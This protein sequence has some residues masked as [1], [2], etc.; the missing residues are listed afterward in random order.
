MKPNQPNHRRPAP[1]STNG[2]LCGRIGSRFQADALAENQREGEARSTCVD[3]HRGTTG[4]VECLELGR[5]PAAVVAEVE[6]PVCDGEVDDRDP[7]RHE[8]RPGAELGAV[9]DGAADQR[10][11]DDREHQLE[12]HEDVLGDGPVGRLEANAVEAEALEAAEELV[13]V[14]AE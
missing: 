13:A 14:R 7:D 11:R 1:S 5:D 2:R 12:R 8:Q 9:G 6:D 3:V 4:E 10:D